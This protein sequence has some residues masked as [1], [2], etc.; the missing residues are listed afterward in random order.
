[1]IDRDCSDSLS[2]KACVSVVYA[3]TA[4]AST[5]LCWGG[6]LDSPLSLMIVEVRGPLDAD[7]GPDQEWIPR[8]DS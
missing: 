6:M 7:A 2:P 3:S 4:P 8:P 5:R 1:M